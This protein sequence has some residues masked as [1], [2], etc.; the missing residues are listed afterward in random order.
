MW[1][2]E[3]RENALPRYILEEYQE[4]AN[5]SA[6]V[7]EVN[8]LKVLQYLLGGELLHQTGNHGP[9]QPRSTV[10]HNPSSG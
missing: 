10:C 4:A 7:S 6:H 3:E 2:Y 5:S 1:V 8:T 9:G